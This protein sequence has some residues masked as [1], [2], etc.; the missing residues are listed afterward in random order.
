MDDSRSFGNSYQTRS[1]NWL[2][3]GKAARYLGISRQ[4]LFD[5]IEELNQIKGELI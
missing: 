3:M 4:R 5:H 1:R 2:S